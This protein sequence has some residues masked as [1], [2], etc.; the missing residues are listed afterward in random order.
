MALN[1]QQ[2]KLELYS[3][4]IIIQSVCVYFPYFYDIM[5]ARVSAL[6]CTIRNKRNLIGRVKG[7]CLYFF[8]EIHNLH[9]LSE[10]NATVRRW[11]LDFEISV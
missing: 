2:L 9:I 3:R 11:L 5:R 7:N 4:F 6:V 1:Y 10:G 8:L